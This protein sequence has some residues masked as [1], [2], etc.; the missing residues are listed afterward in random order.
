MASVSNVALALGN[1]PSATTRNVTVTGTLNFDAGD[2]GKAY[3]LGIAVFGEDKAGD[4]LPSG[5]PVGDDELYT[6]RWGSIF[7][8]LPYRQV[9]VASAGPLPFSEVRTLDAGLLDEDGGKVV[10]GMADIHTPIYST[11]SDEVYARASLSGV[12]S[13]AR[14]ATVIAGFGV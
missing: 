1:G 11:R 12:P 8:K 9:T 6:F 10:I 3:R 4:N 7:L 5:D 14:S 13:T 2:V